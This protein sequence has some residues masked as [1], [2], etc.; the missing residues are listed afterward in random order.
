MTRKRSLFRAAWLL[1]VFALAPMKSVAED[2]GEAQIKAQMARVNMAAAQSYLI[3]MIAKSTCFTMAGHNVAENARQTEATVQIYAAQVGHLIRGHPALGFA[4]EEDAEILA[5][6]EANAAAWTTYQAAARQIVAGDLHAVPMAQVLNLAPVVLSN[7]NAVFEQISTVH[8]AQTFRRK[9]LTNTINMAGRQRML[10]QRAAK[11]HCY[12]ALDIDVQKMRQSL[13]ASVTAFETA[14][15][16][17]ENGDFDLN[18]IDPPSLAV[19]AGV[20]EIRRAWDLYKLPLLRA[21]EGQRPT[22][23][24]VRE[25]ER[26]N[27]PLLAMADALLLHYD[28]Q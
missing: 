2:A 19:L 25:V 28:D 1:C 5:R 4:A 8:R 7:A 3:Q 15:S 22:P 16:A 20:A 24:E 11:A 21:I 17:L 10:I 12:I 23:E 26:T 9:A 18:I 27:M 13:A 14:L 6:F